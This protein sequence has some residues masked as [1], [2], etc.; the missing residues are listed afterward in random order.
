[1]LKRGKRTATIDLKHDIGKG[2]IKRLCTD[3]DVLIEPFRA[4]VM[5]RLGLGPKQMLE[6]NKRLIYAR[7]TGFGQVGPYARRAG[8]D[9]NYLALSGVLSIFTGNKQPIAPMNMLADFAGGG[10]TCALGILMALF[11]RSNSGLGQ[12][13][14]CSMVDGVRYLSSY[15][16]YTQKSELIK[17]FIWPQRGQKEAN[18]L[19]G[20]AHF[21]TTY[22]TKDKR[23]LSVG[24]IEPQFYENLLSVLKLD[25]KDYP[26]LEVEKWPQL[27]RDFA[28]IFAQKTLT[29][30]TELFKEADACL[31][32]ILEI[33][34]ADNV[35]AKLT[36]PSFNKDGT[37]KPAPFLDR[38]PA[39]PNLRDPVSNE[40]T[41]EILREHGYTNEQ[42][43]QWSKDH[44]IDCSIHDNKL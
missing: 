13:V 25:E 12:V 1:M 9:I 10:M 16:W 23:W 26:H 11:E 6:L 41:A 43:V 20:G 44:V 22:E 30:W 35:S 29:E 5:E 24:A 19:D 31:E 18:L 27:K 42:I 14:D 7:L 34:E 21:Y 4:G 15:V 39:E 17:Q 33:D 38:T 28:K 2:I 40:H 32:P 36:K 3:A 8:H 37:P